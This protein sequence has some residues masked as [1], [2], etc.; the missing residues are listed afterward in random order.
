MARQIVANQKITDY[1]N[2]TCHQVFQIV[3]DD[4]GSEHFKTV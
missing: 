3:I 2:E 1:H 4:Y